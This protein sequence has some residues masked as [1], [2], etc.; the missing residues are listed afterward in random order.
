MTAQD[1]IDSCLKSHASCIAAARYCTEVGGRHA[2]PNHLAL[3]LD[4][5]EICQATANSLMR[6][7]PQHGTICNACAA[8]CDACAKDCDSFKGDALLQR[9]AAICREC[10]GHCRMM[11]T[12]SI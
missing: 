5:A 7:S 3:L 1:C 6:R 10:A 4:C 12:I 8:L 11:S 9:C 2:A